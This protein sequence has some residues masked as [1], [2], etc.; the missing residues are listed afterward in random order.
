MKQKKLVKVSSLTIIMLLLLSFSVAPV[1]AADGGASSGTCG[2]NI[3]S[4]KPVVTDLNEKEGS[5]YVEKAAANQ[6]VKKID[7]KLLKDGYI[8]Q[9]TKAF[10]VQVTEQDGS[11]T[12]IYVVAT[13][14]GKDETDQKSIVFME[15]GKTGITSTML[16]KGNAMAQG[17]LTLCILF[18]AGCSIGCASCVVPCAAEA[19]VSDDGAACLVC[20]SIV[21]AIPCAAAIC[22]CANACCD[23]GNQWCCDHRCP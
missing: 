12:S 16:L 6:N 1:M 3:S 22:E 13:V 8:E 7:G 2:A 14:Y 21:C 4:S 18:T 9:E 19:I 15:N 5:I 17:S 20:M 23:A 10:R 11:L